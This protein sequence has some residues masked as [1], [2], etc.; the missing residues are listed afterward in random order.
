MVYNVIKVIGEESLNKCPKFV[1]PHAL[2]FADTVK[3]YVFPTYCSIGKQ[4]IWTLKLASG[5]RIRTIA[6]FY[7]KW[8]L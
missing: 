7:V 5:R 1:N 8:E 4:R 6:R 2:F 3:H